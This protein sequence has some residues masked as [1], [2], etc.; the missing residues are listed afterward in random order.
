MRVTIN[1]DLMIITLIFLKQ[2]FSRFLLEKIKG[3]ILKRQ[4]Q[5][6]NQHFWPSFL[7]L[8]IGNTQQEQQQRDL[9]SERKE[10]LKQ[11]RNNFLA[12]RAMWWWFSWWSIMPVKR[13][14]R[15]VDLS[16]PR[17]QR[18]GN[19]LKGTPEKMKCLNSWKRLMDVLRT[20]E[21]RAP[22]RRIKS[23][24]EQSLLEPHS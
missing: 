24:T 2:V 7:S 12:R 15:T 18:Q 6:A 10:H 5:E 1:R 17:G 16:G 14:K 9:P 23:A 8:H 20:S 11:E 22:S 4:L 3:P 21:D 13:P 19:K